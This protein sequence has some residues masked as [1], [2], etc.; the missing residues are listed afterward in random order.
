MCAILAAIVFFFHRPL[1]SLFVEEL[2]AI[3]AGYTRLSLTG[4]LYFLILPC[5]LQARF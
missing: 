1:L 3:E 2:E 5:Y 4:Y